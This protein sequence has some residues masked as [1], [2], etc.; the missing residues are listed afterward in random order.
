MSNGTQLVLVLVVSG[1]LGLLL[2]IGF[3]LKR[4]ANALEKLADTPKSE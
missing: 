1:A 4:I 2:S 3:N